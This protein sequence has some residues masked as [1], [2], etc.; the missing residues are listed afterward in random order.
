LETKMVAACAGPTRE[1]SPTAS[2][3]ATTALFTEPSR[4]GRT[5]EASEQH[6]PDP[7]LEDR[8]FAR[9]DGLSALTKA[10]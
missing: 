8:I 7:I 4:W 9:F 5:A 10:A 6:S 3:S 1:V 2:T